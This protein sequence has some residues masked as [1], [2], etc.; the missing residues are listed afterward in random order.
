MSNSGFRNLQHFRSEYLLRTGS[1]IS[2][3]VEEIADDIYRVQV[4]AEDVSAESLWDSFDD[5]DE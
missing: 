4:Q 1:S 3:S 2:S 5:D